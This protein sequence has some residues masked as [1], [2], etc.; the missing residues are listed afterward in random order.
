MPTPPTSLF[1]SP[2]IAHISRHAPVIPPASPPPLAAD[3]PA[4]LRH[5][6]LP[7]PCGLCQ[8]LP[9]PPSGHP[10]SSGP[11]SRH[12]VPRHAQAPAATPVHTPVAT[13][14]PRNDDEN[15]C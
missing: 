4:A 9:P 2:V 8:P 12:H 3:S 10:A 5:T 15:G 14:G 13:I 11:S 1:L 6:S 7:N